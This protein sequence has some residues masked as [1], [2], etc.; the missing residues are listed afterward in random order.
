MISKS[1]IYFLSR[2]KITRKK[3]IIKNCDALFANDVSQATQ[4]FESPLNGGWWISQGEKIELKTAQKTELASS[5]LQL[6][7][8]HAH[9]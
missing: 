2:K 9:A 1:I 3:L 4:G 8:S 7:E 6:I 5:L